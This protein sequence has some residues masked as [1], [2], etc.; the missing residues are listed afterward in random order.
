MKFMGIPDRSSAMNR[1]NH[2]LHS[3][4][5]LIAAMLLA[6]AGNMLSLELFVYSVIT[7]IVIYTCIFGQ[8]LLPLMPLFIYAY[9]IPSSKNN[10]GRKAQTIF[11]LEH[12]GIYLIVLGV[13]IAA[14]LL[15]R[16]I[17]DRRN[18]FS[19]KYALLPGILLLALAY[20]TGGLGSGITLAHQGKS[21]VFGFVQGCAILLPYFLFCGGVDWKKVD[22]DYFSW[23]GVSVGFLLLA[24]ILWL[25]LSANVIVDGTIDRN[26]IYT[27]WGI[28]NNIGCT[29]ILM[30]PFAFHLSLKKHF[31]S[32][33]GVLVGSAFLLGAYFTCSRNAIL[34]GTLIYLISLI[35]TLRRAENRKYPALM[36]ILFSGCLLTVFALRSEK[37]LN[38]FSIMLKRGLRL[39]ARDTIWKE[40]L[41]LF[42]QAPIFGT[43]FY[44]PGY[45][46]FDASKIEA[47]SAIFPARWHNTFVQ[48]LTCCGV[49]GLGAYLVHRAQ[50]VKLFFRQRSIENIFVACSLL[51]LLFSSLLDCYFFNIGP[52]LFYSMALA[53]AEN[54][55][56]YAK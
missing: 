1:I 53:Y 40:G 54:S 18:F 31:R 45:V 35:I 42:T 17:R 32:W 34:T 26:R 13:L 33:F 8:D 11:S 6:I 51:A 49:F 15:Y 47:F 20:L 55:H 37:I 3:H 29:L 30:I 2:F 14:S 38:L 5:Y 4:W 50:T 27:G 28:C 10:P 22:K 44:S 16:V 39:S 43:S 24:E 36:L 23:L 7:L 48:L 19:K 25:Y 12:G 9:V 56:S 21:V 41:K 52:G 46:P